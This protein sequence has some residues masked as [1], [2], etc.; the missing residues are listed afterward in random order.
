MV[1]MFVKISQKPS[2]TMR[3]VSEKMC[4]PCD[5]T[6]NHVLSRYNRGSRVERLTKFTI[7]KFVAGYRQKP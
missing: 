3:F 7:S 1:M 6:L 2:R 5:F 4:F